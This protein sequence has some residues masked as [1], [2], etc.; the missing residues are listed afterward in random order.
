[1][2]SE[3]Y[4]RNK[5]FWFQKIN[6]IPE[7]IHLK[8]RPVYLSTRAKRSSFLI[9]KKMFRKINQYCKEQNTSIFVLLIAIFSIYITQV[10]S[11]KNII[12][13]TTTLNRLNYREKNTIGMFINTVP[14]RFDIDQSMEFGPFI[15]KIYTE[16]KNILRNQRYPND[17]LIEEYHQKN[18]ITE[19]LF[20]ITINYQNAE[21]NSIRNFQKVKGRWHSCRH[22][23]NSLNI[24]IYNRDKSSHYVID[25]DYLIELF[26]DSEIEDLHHHLMYLLQDALDNPTQPLAAL[27]MIPSEE[28]QKLIYEFNK[29]QMFLATPNQLLHQSFEAHAIQ[30]PDNIAL[31]FGEERITYGEL[32]RKANQIAWMLR[33]KGIKPDSIVGLLIKRSPEMFYG[34]L[35]IL[36][37]GGAY[38]PIDPD[39]PRSRVK[40]ILEDSSCEILL[41]NDFLIGRTTWKGQIVNFDAALDI[42]ERSNP[43]SINS[44]N[45]LAYVIYTSG[46][47]GKPKGVMIEHRSIVNTVHWRIHYYHFTPG[48]VLLQIPPFNFDSSV[49]DIFSFL[50]VGAAIVIIP[51]EKRLELMYLRKLIAKHKVT[52]F[53]VTP[54]FYHAMLDEIAPDL[55][56]LSSVTV[57][58]EN[59]HLNLVQKHF[60]KLPQVKLYNEYGPTE[61]SVCSTVYQFSSADREIF[62][63]KP[64][65][66]C[67]C[68]VLSPDLNLQPIGVPGELYLGGTGLARGYVANP[69]LTAAKFVHVPDIEGRLYRTGDLVK[70]TPDGNLQFIERIDNQVKIRGFRI[71]LSE[72]EF[73][74]LN[75]PA[76]TEAVV[77][78]GEDDARN[79]F[80][81]AYI[82]A[83][84][85]PTVSELKGFLAKNLPD[86]MIPAHFVFLDKLPLTPNGKINKK[87]LP[88][89]VDEPKV[90]YLPPEN[91]VEEK[92]AVLWQEVLGVTP[93]GTL[94]N[95]F[96]IGG[97]SLAIIRILTMSYNEQWDLTVQDFYRNNNIK[98]LAALIISRRQ[99]V[100]PAVEAQEISDISIPKIESIHRRL[101][102]PVKLATP[103]TVR[104]ILLTGATGFL[105]SH[106]LYE[107][108]QQTD[109]RV[110]A[111]VRGGDTENAKSRLYEIIRFYF[112][113][114]HQWI[115]NQMIVVVKGDITSERF[116]LPEEEY[117][118]LQQKIDTV[119]HTA[120][121]VKHYGDSEEFGRIN[122]QG[123]Q[124]ILQFSM[125]K[126]LF[127]ISTTSVAGDY[128]QQDQ[129][130][131]CLY[132]DSLDIGQNLGG[133]CYVESKFEAE[134]MVSR[135]IQDGCKATIIRVGNLTGRYT[136]GFFQMNIQDNKFYQILKSLIELSTI[137]KTLAK[138]DVEFTPVDLCSKVIVKLLKVEESS[139]KTF[140][141]MNHHFI[142]IKNLTRILLETGYQV[143]IVND[144]IFY[145]YL[146]ERLSHNNMDTLTGL[147]PDLRKGKLNYSASVKV[148][149]RFSVAALKQLNFEWPSI[150]ETYVKKVFTYM[151]SVGFV[152]MLPKDLPKEL[153]RK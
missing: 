8:N 25:Y 63:G 125:G 35:G 78:S 79:K 14:I 114:I 73:Q 89:P 31:I 45:V 118:E 109:I 36:K 72:I 97:D 58:G 21:L 87:A 122:I 66:N 1:M 141:L 6:S 101:I 32:N 90:G 136:D 147:V 137:P 15:K 24:H 152:K 104:N 67:Q 103:R 3:Q 44:P 123:V 139:G 2:L 117:R 142:K 74:L 52:H 150:D 12:F 129:R 115:L 28:K 126:F 145:K 55:V 5:E 93:I 51:K 133:N 41:T 7:F 106:I 61:N 42:E 110:Y 64:I 20:D 22:Q 33:R 116:G 56:H 11:K 124:N 13:G 135:H 57:A 121:L 105:G 127:H 82:V 17:L 94:D 113:Q 140:H 107:L 120:A 119:I 70:W 143:D 60:Q 19:D 68:Y 149:S 76:V 138:K 48:D 69:D 130:N 53:L 4:H 46:S 131:L 30:N 132:E 71:E 112:P 50:S 40:A 85:K 92:L 77:V 62:I 148:D 49:E 128:A 91:E 81:Y 23:T 86:Y 83:T 134:K 99:D 59:F 43:E 38:M 84:Q 75:H 54:L 27:E 144:D 65:P 95:F 98:E 153:S 9:T 102:T 88:A 146:Q 26:T 111:L 10:T 37:A 34:I 80:L 39:F 18:R 151:Q 96:E 108:L 47:T 16:W 29:P 100:K